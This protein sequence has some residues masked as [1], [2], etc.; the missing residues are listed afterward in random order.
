MK[1]GNIYKFRVSQ[2]LF[3]TD[4]RTFAVVPNPFHAKL[5]DMSEKG[6]RLAYTMDNGR[7]REFWVPRNQVTVEPIDEHPASSVGVKDTNFTVAQEVPKCENC[8]YRL[9]AESFS[10]TVKYVLNK[11]RE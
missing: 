6:F 9:M 4:N 1:I 8:Q 5:I 7:V 3:D 2:W 11:E 10:N